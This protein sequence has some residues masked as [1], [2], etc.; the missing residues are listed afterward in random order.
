MSTRTS[1][2]YPE[3]LAKR[4]VSSKASRV[5]LVWRR[6]ATVAR[7]GRTSSTRGGLSAFVECT[8]DGD[9]ARCQSATMPAAATPPTTTKTF[10]PVRPVKFMIFR[11]FEIQLW[12]FRL[13]RRQS[14][15]RHLREPRLRLEIPAMRGVRIERGR[16]PGMPRLQR[17]QDRR[18][19]DERSE[20]CAE[21]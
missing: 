12:L 21:E 11:T 17:G 1:D 13:F 7:R 3:T 15:I 18:Q 8:G 6:W 5:A 14:M 4:S 20:R 2:R 16:N 19:D 10:M 9:A